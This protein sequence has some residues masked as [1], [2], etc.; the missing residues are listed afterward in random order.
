MNQ[1]VTAVLIHGAWANAACW[2]KVIPL[3]HDSGLASVAVQLPLTSLDDDVAT[4]KRALALIDG[5]VTLVGHSYGGVVASEAGND[6][7]VQSLIFVA[8][9]APD[10]GESAGS[11]GAGAA[12]APLGAEIRP[13]AQGFLKLTQT[14]ID[15]SFGQD[16]S[17]TERLIAFV[18]QGPTS[19]QALGGVVAMPAWKSKPSWYVIAEQD[20]AIQP[21]LQ[22]Q[23]AD[24]ARSHKTS[25]ASSHLVMMSHP[26]KVSQVI[27]AAA[28]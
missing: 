10:Q 18:T 25:L 28:K 14:G 19:A 5:P 1:S 17:E 15:E 11:L 4:V 12:P 9:F 16:L 13:D 2:A 27:L 26:E 22:H 23:M 21:V 8:A 7:K 6:S 24:R 20:G 3:L